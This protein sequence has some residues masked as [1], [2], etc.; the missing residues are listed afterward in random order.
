[1]YYSKKFNSIVTFCHLIPMPFLHISDGKMHRGCMSDRS[2]SKMLCSDNERDCYKCNATNC[3]YLHSFQLNNPIEELPFGSP[4]SV[5]GNDSA[6]KPH[7]DEQDLY[8]DIENAYD[9]GDSSTESVGSASDNGDSESESKP[10]KP[11]HKPSHK[12]THKPS[13][14][15]GNSA[16]IPSFC[17]LTIAIAAIF[18]QSL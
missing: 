5:Q 18:T 15:P 4:E 14:K 17:L 8:S 9:D 1:M 3:N 10:N 2:K 11:S 12:P 13:H 6:E 7:R 16:D